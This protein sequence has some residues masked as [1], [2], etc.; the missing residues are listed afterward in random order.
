M[1]PYDVPMIAVASRSFSKNRILRE[2]L[3]ARYPDAKFNDTDRVLS[4]GELAG[5]LRG[6]EKAITGLDVLDEAVFSAVPE[7]RIVSKYGVGLDMI[8]LAAARP[9]ERLTLFMYPFPKYCPNVVSRKS[10][11]V[12]RDILERP[13]E[14]KADGAA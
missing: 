1:C 2:E 3:T 13:I 14:Q 10:R 8:D 12:V 5:F 4:G 9:S 7:L 6:H 11:H